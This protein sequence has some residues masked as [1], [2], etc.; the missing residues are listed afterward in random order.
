LAAAVDEA[1]R[2]ARE[3]RARYASAVEARTAPPPSLS[4]D[5]ADASFDASPMSRLA[6]EYGFI[7]R[8]AGLYIDVTAS[9][10]PPGVPRN[11]FAMAAKNF[12]REWAALR[13]REDNDIV[14]PPRSDVEASFEDG[15]FCEGSTTTSPSPY[16]PTREEVELMSELRDRLDELTLSNEGIWAREA[17]REQVPAPFIIKAPYLVLC[18]FLDLAFPENRPIQRFWFLESVAR[19]PYFSYNTMLT[20]YELLGWWRRGSELRRVHFAEEW[21]EYHHLLVMESL[22]G[23]REWRDRFLAFHSA[24]VYYA[25]LLNL[26]IISPALAYNFSELI[27][28]HAV[29][30][31]AQFAEENK[32]ALRDLP[33]P[34]VARAYWEGEDLYLFD[35]FQTARP[36]S[37]RRPRVKTLHDVFETIRDDEAE[38]VA[39]MREC[40]LEDS[41]MAD[42]RRVDLGTGAVAITVA[43]SAAAW[44]LDLVNLMGGIQGAELAGLEVGEMIDSDGIVQIVANMWP[45]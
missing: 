11:F 12:L 24:L 6:C 7:Q 9:R 38:H 25:V 28:A 30:T 37:S 42:V 27:E 19:M 1:E 13:D 16:V 39:T 34:R 31:Y 44:S 43:A 32:E 29:D 10:S 14:V 18:R 3:A 41:A 15:D 5:E 33:A 23:D 21:N 17:E 22:G 2:D 40:Q 36:R 8:S 26:W 20:V 4:E 35:E 45:F